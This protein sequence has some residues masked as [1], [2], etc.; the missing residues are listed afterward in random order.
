MSRLENP[1]LEEYLSSFVLQRTV[2]SHLSSSTSTSKTVVQQLEIDG[3]TVP[4]YVNEFWTSKQRQSSSIHE[5]SYRACYKPQLPHFF[6][7]LLTRVGD[8]VYDPFSG[9]GTTAI[10][11]GLLGRRVLANDINPLSCLL[12]APRLCIPTIEDVATRLEEIVLT[13]G[14]V[15]NFDLSMFYHLDTEREIVALRNYL[16]SRLEVG[17]QDHI[18]AWIRM[19]ATNRLTGHSPGFFSVYTLPPNQAVSPERQIRINKKR[20]QKPEF[21]HIKGR[22]LKKTRSLL[23]TLNETDLLQL[24]ESAKTAR[25]LTCDARRTAAMINEG[26]VSLTVT[27]PP[28]LDVVK[29]AEDN[30]LRCW[31]NG[32]DATEVALKITT[33]KRLDDWSEIMQ[34]VFHELFRVT[35]AKGWV[36]F[37]V[38]E[39]RKGTIKLDEVV[40][41][42]GLNAGFDCKCIVV[43]L[44]EFTKTS[45]IWG[46]DNNALGTNTN[47]IVVFQK[48]E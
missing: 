10:E 27:S 4:R 17:E 15:A 16:Q 40:V 6:I 19:V 30:W 44:Q 11:A 36:A 35:C 32:I 22:I 18:D 2:D 20:G 28:F 9:R 31:F 24:E 46:V 34:D 42:L 37:E 7:K 23:R 13:G 45:N 43:N 33:A 1:D 3:R 26:S 29:Y 47:R 12:A 14:T 39:V 38:G 48:P 41:P 5:V 25:F 8:L 21:K